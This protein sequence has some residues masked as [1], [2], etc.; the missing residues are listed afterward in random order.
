VDASV[1]DTPLRPRGKAK[2]LVEE[3]KYE[4]S[5]DAEAPTAPEGSAESGSGTVASTKVKKEYASSV[6]GEAGWLK[7]RGKLHFGYK[8]H[9]VTDEQGLVLGILTTPANV[10]EVSNFGEVLDTAELPANIPVSTDKGYKSAKNDQILK[11]RKLKN[12]IIR[13]AVKTSPGRLGRRFSTSWW[14]RQG[15]RW[16]GLSGIRRWFNGGVARYRG[17]AKTHSQNV[18]EALCYNLYRSPGKLC[19]IAKNKGNFPPRRGAFGQ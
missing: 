3:G 1:V 18:L 6:D 7:K 14:A 2:H 17:M 8:K 13:K 10:N 5:E 4:P 15:S 9:V 19:P 11:D 12:R 16:S